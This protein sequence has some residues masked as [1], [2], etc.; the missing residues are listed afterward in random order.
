MASS[1]DRTYGQWW[2]WHGEYVDVAI[3]ELRALGYAAYE[4]AGASPEDARFLF[5]G[6]L[7]KTLQGDHAR[8]IVYSPANIRLARAGTLDLAAPIDVVRERGATAV[9]SGGSNAVGRRG[10]LPSPQSQRRGRRKYSK[11]RVMC[12]KV[13]NSLASLASRSKTHGSLATLSSALRREMSGTST[14]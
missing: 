9:V 5:D 10:R 12:I 4:A 8:G 1:D 14:R 3:D 13:P 11:A 2:D 6:E 7:D